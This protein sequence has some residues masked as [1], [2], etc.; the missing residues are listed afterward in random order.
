MLADTPGNGKPLP[1]GLRRQ[2]LGAGCDR[3][4]LRAAQEGAENAGTT[5]ALDWRTMSLRKP[6]TLTFVMLVHRAWSVR[7]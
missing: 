6:L 4:Q 5:R 2:A 1:A 7:T 3:P